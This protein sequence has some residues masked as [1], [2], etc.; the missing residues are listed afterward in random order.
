[1][2]DWLEIFKAPGSVIKDEYGDVVSVTEMVRTITRRSWDGRVE[3]PDRWFRENHA[4]PGPNGL[5]RH[6]VNE[7]HCIGHGEGTWDYL[8]GEFS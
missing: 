8:V 1:M 7:W 2:K 6:A 4:E 5:A 3:K